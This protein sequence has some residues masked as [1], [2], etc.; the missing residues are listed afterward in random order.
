MT[1]FGAEKS[2][3]TYL[4]GK[5]MWASAPSMLPKEN[6]SR[7]L[8]SV[9]WTNNIRLFSVIFQTLWLAKKIAALTVHSVFILR[10]GT[11]SAL[12]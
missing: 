2:G 12:P 10:D 5:D 7:R 9:D 11:L 6:S 3:R 1:T 8:A 4:A